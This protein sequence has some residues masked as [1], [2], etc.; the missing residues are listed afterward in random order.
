MRATPP[1]TFVALHKSTKAS[2]SKV[3][4]YAVAQLV[5]SVIARRISVL[6]VVTAKSCNAEKETFLA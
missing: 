4:C 1:K 6:S 2:P 3:S 5:V